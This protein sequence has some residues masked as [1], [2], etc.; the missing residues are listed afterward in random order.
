ML[1]GLPLLAT[2]GWTA[3]KKRQGSSIKT[4]DNKPRCCFKDLCFVLFFTNDF[5]YNMLLDELTLLEKYIIVTD[6]DC[7][8]SLETPGKMCMF[9]IIRAALCDLNS[10]V[11]LGFFK[12]HTLKN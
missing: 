11:I 7:V 8:C 1:A 3:G 2:A 5:Y 6:G 12:P 9:S 4:L 10:L